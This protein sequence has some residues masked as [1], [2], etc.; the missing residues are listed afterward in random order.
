MSSAQFTATHWSNERQDGLAS[1]KGQTNQGEA[2]P[3]A[4]TAVANIFTKWNAHKDPCFEMAS[5]GV[6]CLIVPGK[7]HLY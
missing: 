7:S 5:S 2:L 1:R 6:N 3:L 4:F